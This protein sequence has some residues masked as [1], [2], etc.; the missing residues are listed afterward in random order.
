[1]SRKRKKWLSRMLALCLILALLPINTAYADEVD[2]QD[3]VYQTEDIQPA[4]AAAQPEEV[5]LEVK[6]EA[7][8][9]V[10]PEAQPEEAQPEEAQPEEVKP[11][12]AQPEAQPEEVK[13]EAQ[14]EEVKPE[15]QPEVQ[16]EEVKPEEA[17]PE[18]V[19]PEAAVEA[20]PEAP[21]EA[22]QDAAVEEAAEPAEIMLAP[23]AV[24]P[25]AS[26][27][28]ITEIELNFKPVT[29]ITSL[30]DFRQVTYSPSDKI[31]LRS[32]DI[33][34]GYESTTG[35][36]PS[37]YMSDHAY[38]VM[39]EFKVRSDAYVFNST[40][41]KVKV[42]SKYTEISNPI[43]SNQNTLW[44][45][46]SYPSLKNEVSVTFKSRDQWS[47]SI[48]SIYLGPDLSTEYT[49]F[50]SY[51]IGLNQTKNSINKNT[52]Y[53]STQ[54]YSVEIRIKGKNGA[55][56]SPNLTKKDVAINAGTIWKVTRDDSTGYTKIYVNFPKDGSNTEYT[57]QAK[58]ATITTLK[59]EPVTK[60]KA[61]T[62]LKIK[63]KP[64]DKWY[65]F[66]KWVVDDNST[67]ETFNDE[68]LIRARFTMPEGEVYISPAMLRT[69]EVYPKKLTY[70]GKEQAGVYLVDMY[71]AA[72][73]VNDAR[74]AR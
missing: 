44:I 71:S 59:G 32:V 74:R 6:P 15:A 60:A 33:R 5:K 66:E 51:Y 36:T 61:G 46:V 48:S 38:T 35:P 45:R 19:K 64:F 56:I 14:P 43:F 41:T 12:E 65:T 52:T 73:N 10:K 55:I 39:Y 20:Q 22:E 31:Y 42:N 26:Y 54:D 24:S 28:I 72:T 68:K 40:S 57:V 50:V 7:A 11:E 53:D 70:N 34:E 47:G 58:N 18:E 16:P 30:N 1:M 2:T 27:D 62:V 67:D 17:Q 9:E 4:E 29:E 13:P 63:F 69:A 3:A 37:N 8:E 23:A 49:G 25:A 21:V